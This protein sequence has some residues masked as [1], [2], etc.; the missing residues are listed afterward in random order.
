[1]YGR[2]T[3][4]VNNCGEETILKASIGIQARQDGT[5]DQSESYGDIRDPSTV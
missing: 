1:M 4:G 3:M 2:Q 5:L